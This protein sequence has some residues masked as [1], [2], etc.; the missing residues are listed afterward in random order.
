ML[1]NSA[2][3]SVKVGTFKSK[4]INKLDVSMDDKR[5]ICEDSSCSV[6]IDSGINSF[7]D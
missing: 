4:K 3:D 5:E 7:F 6:S 2:L 1:P